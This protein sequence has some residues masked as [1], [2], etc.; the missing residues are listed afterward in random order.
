[1]AQNATAALLADW[2]SLVVTRVAAAVAFAAAAAVALAAAL[3]AAAGALAAACCK[4]VAAFLLGADSAAN[5]RASLGLGRR[6]KGA[7]RL[8]VA[9]PT[10][11]S[12]CMR[13]APPAAEATDETD[14]HATR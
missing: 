2:R 1:M 10:P 9:V 4:V 11:G 6:E 5:P 14:L 13:A 8:A 12:R 3:W 7:C